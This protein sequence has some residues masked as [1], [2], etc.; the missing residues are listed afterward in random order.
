MENK[1]LLRYGTILYDTQITGI[2]NQLIRIRIIKLDEKLYV[3]KMI[4][5]EV[6]II[7]ELDK[8]V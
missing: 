6:T 3:H 5:G 7:K 4:N 1:N 2:S 8:E